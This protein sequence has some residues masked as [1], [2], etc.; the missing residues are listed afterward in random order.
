[1]VYPL[2]NA[3]VAQK[4]NR[5]EFFQDQANKHVSP[6][7]VFVGQTSTFV[8]CGEK[9]LLSNRFQSLFIVTFF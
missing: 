3:H 5:Y 8:A 2:K 4:S 7:V 6:Q 9:L 1:M